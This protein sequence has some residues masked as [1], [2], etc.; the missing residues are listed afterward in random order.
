MDC[1]LPGSSVHE[2]LQARILEYL[3]LH[4]IFPTQGWKLGFLN[5]R[6]ILYYLR[7]QEGPTF[8]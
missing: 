7:H 1:S 6:H 5:C 3:L 4:G 8:K 2:I